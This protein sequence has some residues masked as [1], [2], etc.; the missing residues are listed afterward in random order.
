M[1][2]DGEGIG[3][4]ERAARRGIAEGQGGGW[5]ELCCSAMAAMAM[6]LAAERR[7]RIERSRG[8]ARARPLQ[9]DERG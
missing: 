7:R 1:V 3:G 5:E 4:V 2:E 6:A 9:N 8:R